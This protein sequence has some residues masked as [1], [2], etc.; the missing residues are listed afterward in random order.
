MGG[1][2][3]RGSAMR[4][5]Q[6]SIPSRNELKPEIYVDFNVYNDWQVGKIKSMERDK[7][8]IISY[9]GE[10]EVEYRRI[11]YFKDRTKEKPLF[12][13]DVL[14]RKYCKNS[15]KIEYFLVPSIINVAEWMTWD[16]ISPII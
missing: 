6:R 7:A 16:E 2:D 1:T 5:A 15:H 10:A 11:R 9:D 8:T 12:R 4:A 3:M 13:I 14:H